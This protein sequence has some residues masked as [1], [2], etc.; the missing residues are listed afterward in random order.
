MN[1]VRKHT[2]LLL[3]CIP[4]LYECN[5]SGQKA[6]VLEYETVFEEMLETVTIV[7]N[8][9][10][11]TL[12][13]K[14][15]PVLTMLGKHEN[16]SPAPVLKGD[17]KSLRYYF[18]GLDK[19]FVISYGENG[20]ADTLYMGHLADIAGALED[21]EDHE[22]WQ[23]EYPA[24]EV[25]DQIAEMQGRLS[26]LNQNGQSWQP[27]L[28][29]T[30][31]FNRF[32]QQAL[33]LCPD[34]TLLADVWTDDK[35]AA[36]IFPEPR[37]TDPMTVVFAF[38]DGGAYMNQFGRSFIVNK[39]DSFEYS[40]KK[41]YVIY[42]DAPDCFEAYVI[43]KTLEGN[44]WWLLQSASSKW[45][46][47]VTDW[48]DSSMREGTITFNPDSRSFLLGNNH[49]FIDFS[50]EEPALIFEGVEEVNITTEKS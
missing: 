7:D 15:R 31:V 40:G 22:S 17:A 37:Y 1:D 49:L 48:L 11:G 9:Q 2:L 34:I 8:N 42:N 14:Y 29:Y 38:R 43:G 47:V 23:K 5:P 12:Q 16:L 20:G 25:K 50:D 39:L 3:A 10:F 13:D 18:M 44:W 35:N 30:V 46:T 19:D 33:R 6:P 41:Y 28:C 45:I 4:F 26:E 21:Y 36:L 24:A 27:Q 32:L